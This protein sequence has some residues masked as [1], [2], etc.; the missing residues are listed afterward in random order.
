MAQCLTNVECRTTPA[1]SAQFTH[2][3]IV[4]RQY[5]LISDVDCWYALGAN[6]TAAIGTTGSTFLGARTRVPLAKVASA[7]KI[8][9]IAASA[10]GNASLDIL[11]GS[12]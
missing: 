9:L 6:P 4:G 10:T 11:E 1:A 2:T 12:V 8:A 5:Y 7:T 3:M